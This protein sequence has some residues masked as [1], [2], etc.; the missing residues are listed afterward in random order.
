[1]PLADNDPPTRPVDSDTALDVRAALATLPEEQRTALIL[2]DMAGYPVAEVAARLGVAE[3]TVK[4]RCARG[5]ARLAER[6]GYLRNPEGPGD[7]PLQSSGQ[8]G[9]R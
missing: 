5:R 1:V 7:V 4:S 9:R 2:V 6:L 3:G 8:G